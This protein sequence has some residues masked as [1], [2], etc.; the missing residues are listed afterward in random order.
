VRRRAI[1]VAMS[2]RW[3]RS[4][5]WRALEEAGRVIGIETG[6]RAMITV[7]IACVGIAAIWLI[8]GPDIAQSEL[9]VKLSV[10]GGIGCVFSLNLCLETVHDSSKIISNHPW[11]REPL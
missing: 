10:L 4:V 7:V 2:P 3:R 1:S 9:W 11:N 5:Y 8:F 6:E